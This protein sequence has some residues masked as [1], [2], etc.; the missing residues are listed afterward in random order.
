M[1]AFLCSRF[2]FIR[3]VGGHFKRNK[4]VENKRPEPRKTQNTRNRKYT[5]PVKIK[6]LQND[7]RYIITQL[8]NELQVW[9]F[10]ML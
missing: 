6:I 1:A 4:D 7:L 2:V 5:Y 8:C 10:T 3:L 9:N